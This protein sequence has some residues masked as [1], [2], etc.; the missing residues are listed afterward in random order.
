MVGDDHPVDAVA[1]GL[2]DVLADGV[3]SIWAVLRVD[4]VIAGQPQ[5]PARVAGCG[6]CA[7]SGGSA[8]HE[9]RAG[10]GSQT[11]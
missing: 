8:A 6:R 5:V 9:E 10:T 3:Q 4:V 7:L 11:Q 1:L 2:H